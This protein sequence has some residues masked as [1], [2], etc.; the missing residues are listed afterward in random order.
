[1]DPDQ[2]PN[3]EKGREKLIQQQP[4]ALLK[5]ENKLVK[6]RIIRDIRN[7]FEHEEGD[8]YK[9]V[10]AGNFWGNSYVEHKSKDD[11]KTLSVENYLNEI[12]PYLKDINNLKKSDS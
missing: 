9:P 10:R 3:L 11:R 12:K 1:M 8:Y 4:G 7:L 5:K 6:D 2:G